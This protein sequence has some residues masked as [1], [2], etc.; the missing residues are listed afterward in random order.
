MSVKPPW[1]FGSGLRVKKV[2]RWDGAG[3]SVHTKRPGACRA[4]V[5]PVSGFAV[6]RL[7]PARESARRLYGGLL[8]AKLALRRNGAGC[9]SAW[10]LA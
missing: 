10:V 8:P 3:R 5:G 9:C 6:A 7:L 2:Q 1:A 4:C